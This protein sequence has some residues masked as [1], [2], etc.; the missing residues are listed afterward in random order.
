MRWWWI[1]VFTLACQSGSSDRA[2]PSPEQRSAEEASAVEKAGAGGAASRPADGGP[3]VRL[4]PVPATNAEPEQLGGMCGGIAGFTCPDGAFCDYPDEFGCQQ[5]DAAGVCRLRPEIC[6]MDV[7]PAC[8]CDGK[9][10]SNPC[11][12]AA[13]GTDVAHDGPC[14]GAE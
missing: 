4:P 5:P 11:R 2:T 8:G 6:T 12:A 3:E 9:T 1:A 13:E 14:R 7:R 10:Y